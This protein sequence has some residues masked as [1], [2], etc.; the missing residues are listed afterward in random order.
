MMLII[1]LIMLVAGCTSNTS[2]LGDHYVNQENPMLTEV[3]TTVNTPSDIPGV[4][5]INP[6]PGSNNLSVNGIVSFYFEE[7]GAYSNYYVGLYEKS[8]M[9]GS[10]FDTTTYDFFTNNDLGI[11][12]MKALKPNTEYVIRLESITNG[13]VYYVIYTTGAADNEKPFVERI[14]TSGTQLEIFFNERINTSSITAE[15]V[16]VAGK[17]GDFN[18]IMVSGYYLEQEAYVDFNLSYYESYTVTIKG[19]S[20]LAGNIMDEQTLSITARTI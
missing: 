9:T 1:P 6:A 11:K 13:T 20:D 17:T 5:S 12:T 18:H 2:N 14:A 3:F 10:Y 15:N 19:I 16:N 7:D 8:T 4:T